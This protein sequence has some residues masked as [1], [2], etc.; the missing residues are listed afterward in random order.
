M[1][2]VD[3]SEWIKFFEE[4]DHCTEERLIEKINERK[5]IAYVDFILL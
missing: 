4:N 1:I 5:F 2:L 3:T